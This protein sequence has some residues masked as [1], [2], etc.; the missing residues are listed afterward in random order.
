MLRAQYFMKGDLQQI[1]QEKGVRPIGQKPVLARAVAD[2][3]TS[4]ELTECERKLGG[5]AAP[6]RRRLQQGIA[7]NKTLSPSDATSTSAGSS[8]VDPKGDADCSESN[9]SPSGYDG[10]QPYRIG[11]RLSC[12]YTEGERAGARR[13]FTVVDYI[14]LTH[15]P[16]IQVREDDSEHIGRELSSYYISEMEDVR[17]I[18]S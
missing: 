5:A 6:K 4:A 13:A 17:I 11:Q 14:S 16:R 8:S 10:P 1:L 15:G 18:A 12:I 7:N 2:H 9:S 3:F